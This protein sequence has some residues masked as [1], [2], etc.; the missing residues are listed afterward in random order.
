MRETLINVSPKPTEIKERTVRWELRLEPL[1]RVELDLNITPLVESREN[2][3]RRS[4]RW[5]ISCASGERILHV[6]NR[7]S[8]NFSDRQ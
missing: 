7:A 4:T 5:T 1:K 8:T 2:H 6:G 3:E